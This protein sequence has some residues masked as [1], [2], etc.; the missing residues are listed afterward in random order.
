MVVAEARSPDHS[1]LTRRCV[2]M[3]LSDFT[4][5]RFLESK[6][7][8]AA[9]VLIL[10]P[11]NIS[12]ISEDVIQVVTSEVFLHTISLNTFYVHFLFLFYDQDSISAL[13]ISS[14]QNSSFQSQWYHKQSI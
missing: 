9:A 13:F 12:T 4:V 8:K 5:D 7:Q 2:I 6:R 10:I 14:T 3:K 11:Q 1:S